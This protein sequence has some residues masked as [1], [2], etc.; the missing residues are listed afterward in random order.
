MRRKIRGLVQT[1][2]AERGGRGQGLRSPCGPATPVVLFLVFAAL[3]CA[4]PPVCLASVTVSVAP[5][6]ATNEAGTE[7]SI[8]VTFVS[9]GF[10]LANTRV[11]FRITAG[12]NAG[13]EQTLIADRDGKVVFRYTSNGE[14]GT[15]TIEIVG[16]DPDTNETIRCP[17][18][19]KTWVK[20]AEEPPEEDPP[21]PDVPRL[22][23]HT[24]LDMNAL[25]RDLLSDLE[26]F[27]YTLLF[28][29]N[30]LRDGLWTL[31][32]LFESLPPLEG[33]LLNNL[34]D[35]AGIPMRTIHE[36][37]RE[38]ANDLDIAR[39]C[40][41]VAKAQGTSGS[42]S[43]TQDVLETL[44]TAKGRLKELRELEHRGAAA[45]FMEEL[46]ELEDYLGDV[47]LEWASTPDD[48]KLLTQLDS[49]ASGLDF[50]L[51]AL[52][53]V[54]GVSFSDLRAHLAELDKLLG[55]HFREDP[56]SL[57]SLVAGF[58]SKSTDADRDAIA[59]ILQEMKR[60]KEALEAAIHRWF[61]CG[62]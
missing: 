16:T 52:P 23:R 3:L 20:P 26:N 33:G 48:E 12:P 32:N 27:R 22:L 44:N 41:T 47:M 17:S 2:G 62:S 49:F 5:E 61:G 31:S 19:T 28:H 50:S 11:T 37:F 60:H 10:K 45:Q 15:D 51:S 34:P 39:R 46:F 4:F 21:V 36:C 54:N 30:F 38:I 56:S 8:T 1:T 6:A 25:L 9:D 42:P 18:A 29:P 59:A 57:R 35:V 24:L 53:D 14:S 58:S 40:V 13:L 43:V 7:H 55:D